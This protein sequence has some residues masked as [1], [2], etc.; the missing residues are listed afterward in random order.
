VWATVI[1]LVGVV[2]GGWEMAMR[3]ADLGPEYIDNRA[4]WSQTRNR[5]N[6][7]GQNA[8]ALLGASRMQRAIDVDAMSKAFGRPV[9]QLAVEGTSALPLLENLAADP[10]FRGTVIYSIAPAFS[11]NRQLSK[12]DGGNQAK[13]LRYYLDQSRVRRAEQDLRLSLQ[14]MLA[15]RS[16]DASIGRVMAGLFGQG[17]LPEPDFKRVYADRSIDIDYSIMPGRTDRAGIVDLYKENTEPYSDDEYQ[18]VIDYFAA[19]T[20]I[21]KQKG[22]DVYVVRLPSEQEVLTIERQMFPKR[23]FWDTLERQVDARFVHFRDYREMEG[24]LSQDGSH[25]DSNRKTAF[26]EVLANVLKKNSLQ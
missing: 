6:A 18:T 22:V 15:S 21:L 20:S 5:L 23:R 11:F 7:N 9:Y 10:R 3:S 12:L 1:V 13:W 16:P 17:R 2:F 24:Y 4:L 14:G 25:I 8:I 26:T 19:L